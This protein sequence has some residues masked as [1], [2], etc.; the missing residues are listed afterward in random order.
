MAKLSKPG[1]ASS[2]GQKHGQ[3]PVQKPEQKPRKKPA[4]KPATSDAPEASATTSRLERSLRSRER[5]VVTPEGVPLVFRVASA[6]E[7]AGAFITDALIVLTVVVLLSTF[8]V[9]SLAFIPWLAFTLVALTIFF[10]RH[11][12]FI[13]FEIRWQGRTPGKRLLGL[14][15]IDRNGGP[16]S[17]AA[18]VARNL[19]REMETIV[20]VFAILSQLSQPDG[21]A[22]LALLSVLWLAVFLLMPLLNRDRLRVGDLIAGTMVVEAPRRGLRR[23]LTARA[24]A[25]AERESRYTFT[26]EQLD[27]YGIYELQVLERLLRRSRTDLESLEAVCEK[28]KRKIGWDQREWKVDTVRFLEEFYRAQRARLEHRMLFGDRQEKKVRGRLRRK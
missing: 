28:I 15:V 13:T 1:G 6:G 5:I 18:V 22:W 26:R 19:T 16:V 21:M 9:F 24:P 27:L 3:N 8:F 11:F 4:P 7:R 17:T 23:D 20:P 2:P 12:Y 14:R 10:F 25:R